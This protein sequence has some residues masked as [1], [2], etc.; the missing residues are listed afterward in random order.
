MAKLLIIFELKAKIYDTPYKNKPEDTELDGFSL[1]CKEEI[2]YAMSLST[3]EHISALFMMTPYAYR[4]SSVGRER[5]QKLSTLECTAH[6][7]V[8]T[9]KKTTDK[10]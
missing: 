8:L 4:T 10:V 2:K 7:Y 3:P 1:V 9:Y 6:F 5:V